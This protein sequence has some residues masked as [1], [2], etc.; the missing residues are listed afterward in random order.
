[1]EHFDSSEEE[2][3]VSEKRVQFCVKKYEDLRMRLYGH[4]EIPRHILQERSVIC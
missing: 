3:S 2:S 4:F 1:M